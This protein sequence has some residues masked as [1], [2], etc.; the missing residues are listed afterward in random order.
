M[1]IKSDN[2][3]ADL[4]GTD[5]TSNITGPAIWLGHIA[6]YAI[7][8]VFTGSPDGAF[9]LQGSCDEYDPKNPLG[10]S[11]TNWTDIGGS[12]QPITASGDH[13]WSAENA[14]Y[15][16]VRLVWTDSASGSPSTIT[17]ARFM[18]KGC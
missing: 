13:M 1:R 9:K 7:Q 16:F 17:S 8:L 18:V 12:N 3:L 10:T 2:I 5:M 11:I 14:G 6:N 4:S 15:T